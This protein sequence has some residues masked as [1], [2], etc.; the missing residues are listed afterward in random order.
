MT[1]LFFLFLFCTGLIGLL[2]AAILFW[3][4]RGHPLA[5][6][7]LAGVLS[8][9]SVVLIGNSLYVTR[10]FIEYPHLYR[11]FS[12]ASFCIGPLSFLYVRTLIN[13]TRS[14]GKPDLLFFAPALLYQLH[15]L[16][17]LIQDTEQKRAIVSRALLDTRN[18]AGEPE[19]WLPF[20]WAA[21]FRLMVGLAFICAQ[22]RLLIR[23]KRQLDADQYLFAL[24][25]PV[26]RWLNWYTF[27]MLFSYAIVLAETL[28]QVLGNTTLG[29]P[30]VST[31]GLNVIFIS[32]YLFARPE[33]LYGTPV[34]QQPL[35][36]TVHPGPAIAAP[37]P[38]SGYPEVKRI[39][40]TA[41]ELKAYRASIEAHLSEKKPF[42]SPGYSIHDLSKEVNIPMYQVSAFINQ[43]Y[44]KSFTEWINDHRFSYLKQ[45]QQENGDFHRYTLE[46]LGKLVGFNSRT[47]FIA[48]IKKRTGKTPSEY[49]LRN[50]AGV[51]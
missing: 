32:G 44:G 42:S 26:F 40:L 27:V 20:G 28:L 4:N 50:S 39:S 35:C 19:G 30:I 15:R 38:E 48:A 34:R 21:L 37:S 36:A 2:A 43:E 22:C 49:F 5:S 25:A 6:R 1:Q 8:A 9:L 3:I 7:L 13:P 33:I 14:L 45:L 23:W 46:A 17:F 24:Q 29:V 10:F 18:I 16:P 11:L 12:A 41:A 31:I 47:S 51:E